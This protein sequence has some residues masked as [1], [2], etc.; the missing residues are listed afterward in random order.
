MRNAA[1]T[2]IP[3]PGPLS[4]IAGCSSGIEPLFALSYIHN[5]LDGAHM[6]EVNPFFE[7]AAKEGGFYSEELMEQLATGTQLH[8]LKNIPDS[9]KRVFVTPP[10]ISPEWHVKMQ[11]AFQKSTHNAV[12][13]TVNFSEHATREDI[14]KVYLMAYDLG[15]KGITVYRDKSREFQPLST[16]PVEK[17]VEK[18][19]GV[20]RS[21]RERP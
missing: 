21:P 11:A 17:K 6:V 9:I 4:I 12:S 5:I 8:D 19:E 2:P 10:E 1:C 18:A 7:E 16:A 3:P 13:K 15:L 20:K 14:S